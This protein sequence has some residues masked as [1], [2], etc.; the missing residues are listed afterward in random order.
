MP[1]AGIHSRLKMTRRKTDNQQA[2]LGV[3]A[4][5][6]M[7]SF[8]KSTTNHGIQ[9]TWKV[10][11]EKVQKVV[12]WRRRSRQ[13]NKSYAL[14]LLTKNRYNLRGRHLKHKSRQGPNWQ[15]CVKGVPFA[16]WWLVLAYK[17]CLPKLTKASIQVNIAVGKSGPSGMQT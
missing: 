11:R 8:P 17:Q 9:E 16:V 6:E 1:T 5:L 15:P 14:A 2:D 13:L 3:S 10:K 4:P 7:P 12:T